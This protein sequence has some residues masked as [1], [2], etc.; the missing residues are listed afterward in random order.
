[1]ELQS[2]K[3][4]GSSSAHTA[5]ARSSDRRLRWLA[6]NFW[7]KRASF[8]ICKCQ[9]SECFKEEDIFTFQ[10][11]FV[12][13]LVSYII[14]VVI[15]TITGN[16]KQEYYEHWFIIQ[17]SEKTFCMFQI[18]IIF[19]SSLPQSLLICKQLDRMGIMWDETKIHSSCWAEPS[20]CSSL[21]DI[22]TYFK[23]KH[24]SVKKLP[25]LFINS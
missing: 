8:D 7:R 6:L 13:S 2:R 10:N 18:Y 11:T 14:P 4:R 5:P 25:D 22:K 23:D 1:M 12:T 24:Y 21:W 17:V 16:D 3:R 9:S 15:E 20:A 19:T